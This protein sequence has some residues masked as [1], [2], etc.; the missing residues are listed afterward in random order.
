[1]LDVA[2]ADLYRK[3]SANNWG[4]ITALIDAA[5]TVIADN[6][7]LSQPI[8]TCRQLSRQHFKQ[9]VAIVLRVSINIF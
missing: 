2:G 7:D 4:V 3:K 6:L 8:T 5:N 9:Q 1:M